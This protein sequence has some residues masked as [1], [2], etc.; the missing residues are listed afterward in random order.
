MSSNEQVTQQ[1][2]HLGEIA[3]VLYAMWIE[4]EWESVVAE[5]GLDLG[6]G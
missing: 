4:R 3:V 1:G 5:E 2:W 6:R